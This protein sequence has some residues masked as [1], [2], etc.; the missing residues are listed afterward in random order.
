MNKTA[1]IAILGIGTAV[2]EFQLDQADTAQRISEALQ[3]GGHDHA[4]RWAKRLF[5]QCGVQSRYTCEPNLLEKAEHSR[6]FPSA[7]SH[8]VPSTGE[9]MRTY[10]RESVPLVIEACRKALDDGQVAVDEV[11]H[12]ITVSCTGQF[13]PGLDTVLVKELGLHTEVNRIPLNFLG[14]AAGLKA[15]CMAKELAAAHSANTVLIVSV[16]LCTLHIQPSSDRE[17]LY[18]ASFFGDGSSACVVGDSSVHARRGI[19]ELGKAR[20]VLFSDCAEHMV[21][22]VED[23]GFDLFLSTDIP[24]LIGKF[25]PAEVKKVI[26]GN[27][28][29][30]LWAIHPG[31]KG[32]IDTLAQI[33]N[34]TEEQTEASRS[35]LRHYGNMSSA[36]ILFVLDA[37]RRQLAANDTIEANGLALAFG[38]GLT[39]EMIQI[40]YCEQGQH[41]LQR[42]EKSDKGRLNGAYV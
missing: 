17:A 41:K 12:L 42:H 30:S 23:Y 27:T 26:G 2:P 33:F 29:N 21:W 8:T 32:I 7:A 6:Y 16:E 35:V 15:I 24:K 36:T 20:S 37:M 31:G 3:A 39:C 38:P 40:S 14:C 10:K 18:G 19:F 28:E 9:R 22:E 5:R 25:V 13:L 34:L 11:T 1:N 4:S